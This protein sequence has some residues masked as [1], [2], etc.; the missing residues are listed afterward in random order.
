[1]N[2]VI[3][4]SKQFFLKCEF[5]STYS[6]MNSDK[7]TANQEKMNQDSVSKITA[8]QNV[9]RNKFKKAYKNRLDHEHDVNQ[10]MKPLTVTSSSTL[11]DNLESKNSNFSKTVNG[12]PQLRL[13]TK[14]F[15]NHAIKSELIK[16]NKEKHR[17]PNALCD[18][19]RMLLSSQHASGAHS[20]LTVNKILEELHDLEIII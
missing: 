12:A 6:K 19:L 1:M 14:S 8:T 13:P 17:D 10:A 3:F 20:T 7:S 16:T 15:S 2:N 4:H 11:T 18:S 5:I 9:I